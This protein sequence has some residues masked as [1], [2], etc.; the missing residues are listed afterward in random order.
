MNPYKMPTPQEKAQCVSWFIETK[1][2]VKTQRNYRDKCRKDP[3][4]RPSICAWQKKF[5]TT[6]RVLHKGRSEQPRTSGKGINRLRQ[7]FYCSPTK[8]FCNATR[9][10]A[11]PGSTVDKVLH[12]S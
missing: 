3:P 5:M 11:Q 9:Q 8:S 4:S 10:L 7:A 12:K 6:G 2:N 1:S